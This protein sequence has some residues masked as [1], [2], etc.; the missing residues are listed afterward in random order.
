MQITKTKYL[1]YFFR[2]NYN[3]NQEKNTFSAFVPEGK[4]G[5]W[6]LTEDSEKKKIFQK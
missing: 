1:T 4:K 2:Q 3:L 6:I 5:F